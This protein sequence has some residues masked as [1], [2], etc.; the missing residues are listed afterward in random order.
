MLN[1]IEFPWTTKDTE[2]LAQA[3]SAFR[4]GKRFTRAVAILLG[5]L[6]GSFGLTIISQQPWAGLV[7]AG[8]G[9]FLFLNGTGVL[10]GLKLSQRN[11]LS[12]TA[13]YYIAISENGLTTKK[14]T[15]EGVASDIYPWEAFE[16][17][18]VDGNGL[19]LAFYGKDEIW[20]PSTAFPSPADKDA[21]MGLVN[22]FTQSA[23][24][25][26]TPL[27]RVLVSIARLFGR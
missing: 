15:Q 17:I 12:A 11:A 6:S 10:S 3:R 4:V 24:R 2:C 18:A 16:D 20:I 7:C 5:L 26:R 27:L 9:I 14:T 1:K 22:T 8:V 19:L 13:S 25:K 21:F 23:S